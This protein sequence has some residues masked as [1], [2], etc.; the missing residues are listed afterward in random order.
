MV[1]I[2]CGSCSTIRLRS[3]ERRGLGQEDGVL[4]E[5]PQG[6]IYHM[7]SVSFSPSL[8]LSVCLS[9]SPAEHSVI[10]HSPVGAGSKSAQLDHTHQS[11]PA[12][13]MGHL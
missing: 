12:L 6:F 8:V 5:D 10:S 4:I 1:I 3:N 2:N 11:Q 9:S 13:R 7:T